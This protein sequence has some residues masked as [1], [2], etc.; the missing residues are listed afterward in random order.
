VNYVSTIF[1][2]AAPIA[3]G[4]G[5]APFTGLF[6][7]DAS[8]DGFNN[9]AAQ[10]DWLLRIGD[11]TT[12][13]TGT[14]N[15]WSLALC[16]DTS[17]ARVCGNG[18]V[19]GTE[20]CDDGNTNSNDGCSN[21]CQLELGCA[22]G[23]TAI[24][25]TSADAKAIIQDNTAAGITSTIAVAGAGNVQKAVV[26]LNSVGHQFDGDLNFT[27]TAP[28]AATVDVSSGNG[29]SGDDFISTM[30][31]DSATTSIVG[32]LS[33]SA[34]FRGQFKP[35]AVLSTVNGQAAAGNWSL[36]AADVASIDAGIFRS[37]TIGLCVQ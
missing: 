10:G 17:A 15:S 14:L 3:I 2:D 21:Q 23:Q 30:F 31:T 28:N 35:E 18:F 20:T 37:W 22:V 5:V 34:P 24:I 36:K 25:T 12:G 4:S 13:T 29:S 32:V 7:P 1:A 26:V 33:A 6:R 9:Q 8:L 11:D 27:L 16:V 19:E